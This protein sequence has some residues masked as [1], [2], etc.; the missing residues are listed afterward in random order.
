M[1]MKDR[2]KWW[3]SWNW[4]NPTQ[5]SHIARKIKV[6]QAKGIH[7]PSFIANCITKPELAAA[8][9]QVRQGIMNT[10]LAGEMLHCWVV[11]CTSTMAWYLTANDT[12]WSFSIYPE[13]F[14]THDMLIKICWTVRP[15]YS[16]IFRHNQCILPVPLL[17]L[18]SRLT[19]VRNNNDLNR[20]RIIIVEPQ[21]RL[22][23]PRWT[24]HCPGD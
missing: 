5:V 8:S 20:A 4:F 12:Q 3:H 21:K 13:H 22:Q 11:K 10:N 9:H 19:V 1:H 24:F 14:Q 6:F 17:F 16:I 15:M 18:R 2:K 23:N 7:D